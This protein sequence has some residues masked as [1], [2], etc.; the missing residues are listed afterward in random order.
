M[1]AQGIDPDLPTIRVSGEGVGLF[2]RRAQ[3]GSVFRFGQYS[4]NNQVGNVAQGNKLR[5]L[6]SSKGKLPS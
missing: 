4:I 2:Q 5:H 1:S 3:L 6:C